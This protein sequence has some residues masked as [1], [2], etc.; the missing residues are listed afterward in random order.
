MKK[1]LLFASLIAVY[2]FACANPKEVTDGQENKKTNKKKVETAHFWNQLEY[3]SM[4]H[5]ILQERFLNLN[6]TANQPENLRNKS[7]IVSTHWDDEF[8]TEEQF[9]SEGAFSK[10]MPYSQSR[11]TIATPAALL[12]NPGAINEISYDWFHPDQWFKSLDLEFYTEGVHAN[13]QRVE[14]SNLIQMKLTY[15]AHLQAYEGDGGFGSMLGISF[16]FTGKYEH[17]KIF[18]IP[19]SYY[20]LAV[21]YSP[22]CSTPAIELAVQVYFS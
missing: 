13:Y 15:P 14:N 11:F 1:V 21:I 3:D 8:D 4:Y 16:D 5:F 12:T 22:S 19:K 2:F 9:N 7:F 6:I 20:S 10:K 17:D 18:I